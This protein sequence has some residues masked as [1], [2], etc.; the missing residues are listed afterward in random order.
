MSTELVSIVVPV[1]NVEKYIKACVESI[2]AQTHRNFELLIIDDESP[3]D[4][5]AIVKQIN[6]ARIRIISQKNRGLA[7]A[8]NTGIRNAKADIIAFLDSDDTWEPEKLAR[9]VS[10]LNA[11]P[12]VGLSFSSSMFIN[13]DG[14][15]L[16]RIQQPINKKDFSAQR[17]FCRNPVGNGS[18]PVIRKSTLNAIAFKSDKSTEFQ[19]FDESLRQSEDIDCW[20]RIALQTNDEFAYIDEPLTNYRLNSGGL[21]ANVDKQFE[22]WLRVLE[23]V[24]TINAT[25]AQKYGPLAKAYQYRYL[26]RRLVM[27]GNATKALGLLNKAIQSDASF[28]IKEPMRS[29]TTII[30]A[31]LFS[32]LPARLQRKLAS[33]V[34]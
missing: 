8:R 2:R 6:D 1:Y 18:A 28:I 31:L 27:E 24:T 13:E 34:I 22:S 5:I 7:G 33:M 11:N 15:S 4:S 9:H 25:F 32:I 29:M 16:N 26:A 20:I 14:E 23:K 12:N 10:Q 19:Y 17:I 21:S 3:D 30:A